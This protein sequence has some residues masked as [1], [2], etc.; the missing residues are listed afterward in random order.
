MNR[1]PKVLLWSWLLSSSI[2]SA[3]EWSKDPQHPNI[4]WLISE[5]MGRDLGC[6]GVKVHTPNIDALAAAGVRHTRM[7][8]TGS[9]C[10]PNRTAM[11]LGLP[12]TTV[13]AVTMRPPAKFMR[14]LPGEMAPLPELMQRIGYVTGN[15]S[16]TT[17]GTHGKDDWNFR[18]TGKSWDTHDVNGLKTGKPFYA[19]FN[20]HE[21]HRT[22]SHD[23]RRPI[24]PQSVVLPPYLPDHPVARQDWALYL[25]SV[26]IL[27]RNVGL[28][29]DWVRQ[30]GLADS[31]IIFFLSDHGVESLRGKGS[32]YDEGF[33]QPLIIRWPTG[34]NPPLG[35][36]PGQVDDRLISAIDL[37][38]QTIDMAGGKVPAWMQG[39]V[40]HGKNS[41]P[42]RDALFSAN[43]SIGGVWLR[44]R[45]V[46]TDQFHYIRNYITDLS[47][48]ESQSEYKMATN[49]NYALVNIL[50]ERNE[51]SPLH[52]RL[53]V[54]K[55]PPDELYDIKADPYELN[56]L[57]GV[58]AYGTV[59]QELKGRLDRWI[60]ESG[61]LRFEPLAPEH[62]AFFTKYRAD[63]AKDLAK[64]I[65][66][67]HDSVQSS[68]EHHAVKK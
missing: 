66:A 51:L 37:A 50:A 8:G 53:Y 67:L 23:A 19:Q 7:Y 1:W 65:T 18:Y 15:I 30:E 68:V 17:M 16:S 39:R 55:L 12:Q 62:I 3:A 57:A 14:A 13:G 24:D 63:Q 33:K 21:S 48:L 44:S 42:A 64:K 6:Y 56:N 22:Y 5:D 47:V 46:R 34:C 35:W 20:F 25:E 59:Q 60:H 4:I 28:V 49:P 31:T 45:T 9:V 2:V 11:M 43:D 27:D 10:M 58:A 40:F 29:L 41:S 38:P 54:D 52:R 36:R 26:Q 32:A 61:D